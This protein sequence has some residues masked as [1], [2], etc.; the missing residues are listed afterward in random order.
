MKNEDIH[1]MQTKD[2]EKKDHQNRESYKDIL[3]K[4]LEKVPNRRRSRWRMK[5]LKIERTKK[6]NLFIAPPIKIYDGVA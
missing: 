3:V 2:Y 6:S 1:A 4:D 5:I